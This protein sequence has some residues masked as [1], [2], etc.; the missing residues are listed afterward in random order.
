MPPLSKHSSWDLGLGS[1]PILGRAWPERA[2]H[3]LLGPCAGHGHEQSRA[4]PA[5]RNAARR[6]HS[7][8]LL[9]GLGS[10]TR[11]DD[12]NSSRAYRPLPTKGSLAIAPTVTF[13]NTT[14]GT[15][16]CFTSLWIE[17]ASYCSSAPRLSIYLTN[18]RL[19]CM[20]WQPTHGVVISL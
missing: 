1:K 18:S 17:R 12:G 4:S 10:S 8:G 13:S 5:I 11:P 3:E 2:R 19:Y 7:H 20:R 9:L 16:L 14:S 6:R 15:R